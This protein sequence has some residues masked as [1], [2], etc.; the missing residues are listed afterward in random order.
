[1]ATLAEVTDPA[2]AAAAAAARESATAKEGGRAARR[3]SSA[4]G[5]NKR[6][7]FRLAEAPRAAHQFF[8]E[9]AQVQT[10]NPNTKA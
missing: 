9:N 2:A 4:K 1:M 7:T 5:Q 3:N 10:L 6:T 8:R